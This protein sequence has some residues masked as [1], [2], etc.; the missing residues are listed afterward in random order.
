MR[1]VNPVRMRLCVLSRC[2]QI[3]A[4]WARRYSGV[5]FLETKMSA[6]RGSLSVTLSIVLSVS[7]LA[8]P[9]LG[10][11]GLGSGTVVSAERAH[12]GTAAASAGATVFPG[13]QLDTE[14]V[15]SLQIRAGAARLVLTSSSHLVWG[16][17]GGSASAT[18]TGGTAAFSTAGAKAFV[19]HA[20]TAAFKPRGDEPTVAN[21]TLLNAK[22]L[23]VRCSRGAVLIAVED[24]VR[25][26]PEGTAYHVVLDPEAAG[27]PGEV[28]AP[29]A[30][31]SWGQ[32]PPIKAGKSQVILYAIAF[33]A[34]I[35]RFAL[36]GGIGSPRPPERVIKY[37][38]FVFY[39][40]G[41]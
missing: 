27:R 41:L 14:Q 26:I 40:S 10:N 31:G 21:V 30:P 4:L 24:D 22:E 6:V 15:G 32:N 1:T 33:T 13:D 2:L 11:S 9:I 34:A 23:L 19:L 5:A 20:G 37:L 17:E 36:S 16:A 28:P 38:V 12:V 18:L 39:F 3:D 35:T 29:A 8:K 7:L 25:M